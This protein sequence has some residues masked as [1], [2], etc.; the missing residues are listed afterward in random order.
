MGNYKHDTTLD[1]YF[2]LVKLDNSLL[3]HTYIYERERSSVK[4]ELIQ[5]FK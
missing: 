3:N 4:Y 1:F 2:I 5:R